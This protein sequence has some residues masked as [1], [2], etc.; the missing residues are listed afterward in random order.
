MILGR[1]SLR[2]FNQVIDFV[3]QATPTIL[4]KRFCNGLKKL[5]PVTAFSP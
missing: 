2:Y 3:A 1:L 5:M 4:L